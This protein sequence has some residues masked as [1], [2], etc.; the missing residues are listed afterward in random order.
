MAGYLMVLPSQQKKATE[1][2]CFSSPKL[3]T[4]DVPGR[5]IPPLDQMGV[6]P[7]TPTGIGKGIGQKLL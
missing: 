2:V 4:E 6:P 3:V 1:T 7:K 5:V